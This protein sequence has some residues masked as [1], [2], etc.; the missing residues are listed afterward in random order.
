MSSCITVKPFPIC[1][2]HYTF[3]SAMAYRDTRLSC[4]RF[5]CKSYPNRQR[6][7]YP[8][9]NHPLA[10][11]SREKAT[12]LLSIIPYGPECLTF[13]LL[14]ICNRKDRAKWLPL[15][16]TNN[17]GA[18]CSLVE[19]LFSITTCFLH[20]LFLLMGCSRATVLAGVRPSQSA[21]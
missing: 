14:Q 5:G 10:N 6:P 9:L 20:R 16:S 15:D 7:S 1:L 3:K 4:R 12:I 17:V 11:I 21:Q 2:N 18:R 8:C 13:C 19:Q